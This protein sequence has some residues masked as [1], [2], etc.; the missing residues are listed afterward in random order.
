MPVVLLVHPDTKGKT[1][2]FL[3]AYYK[4]LI[5]TAFRNIVNLTEEGNLVVQLVGRWNTR[6][7]AWNK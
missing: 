1:Q 7:I 6:I 2:E 5:T 3:P 4:D